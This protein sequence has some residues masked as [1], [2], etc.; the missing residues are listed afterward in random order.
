MY[1]SI[2]THNDFDGVASAALCSFVYKIDRI[3]FAGP[4][5]ITKSQLSISKNDIVCDLPYPLECGLWFDHH[6]GNR[7]ELSYRNIDLHSIPGRFDV[8]PSCA[9]VVYDHF[10]SEIQFP[11]Y[12]GELVKE[13]D[14]IDSF[15][16]RDVD[17]WRKLT[18]GKIIDYAIKSDYESIGEQYGFLRRLVMTMRDKP[19]LELSTSQEI[20]KRFELYQR[21]EEEMLDVIRKNSE[22]LRSDPNKEIVLI[23]LRQYNQPLRLQK[24]LAFLLYPEAK[25]VLEIKAL[26]RNRF[27]T[28]DIGLSMSLSVIMNNMEHS[29]DVGEVMREL[30]IGDGHAGAAAGTL[31]HASKDEMIRG[32]NRVLDEIVAI[33]S[34]Q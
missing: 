19:I 3:Q 14:V 6:E 2:I 23:D 20:Q 11:D 16:Y 12:Y 22:F 24:N 1:E 27:K 25:A 4:S 29:K 17:D 34:S 10:K 28:N 15:D 9:H 26:F 30:N 31:Y 21:N 33:W 7:D 18:P 32:V 13:A 8:Q 5:A